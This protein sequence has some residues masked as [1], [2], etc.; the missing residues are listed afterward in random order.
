MKKKDGSFR[1]CIDCRELNKLTIKNRYPLLRIDDLFD[2]LQGSRYFLK[3]DLRSGYHQLRVREEDIPKTTFRTSEGIH[4]DPIKIE[5]VKNWKHPKTPT[6]FRSL[7]RLVGNFWRFIANFLKIAK[8]LTLLTQKDKKFEWGDEQENVFQTLKDML[9]DAPILRNKVI[10]YASRQLKIHE[11]NYTTYDLEL[12]TVRRWIELFSDYDCEIRCHPG[13][14]NVVAYPLSRKEWMKLRQARAMSMTIHSSI[15]AKILEA[16]SEASK[17]VNTLAEMLRGLDK[18]FERKE[19]GGLYFVERVWV[20]AYGNL[21]TLIMNEAHATKIKKDIALYVSKCLTCYKVKAEHQKPSGLLQQPEIPEWKWENITMDFIMKLPRTSSR[22]DSIWVIV[23]RLTKSAHFL[24]IRE[25]YRTEKLARLYINEIKALGTQLDLSTAYH[26][27][28]DGQI[29]IALP[30]PSLPLLLQS[31]YIPPLVD[32]RDD[33]LESEQPPRKSTVDAEERRQGI[34]NVGY[35]I[36]DT[37]VDPAEAV[38]E[39]AHMT[40]G[41]E[42]VWMAE[43]EAYASRE[44]WAHSIGL[45]QATHQEL[46]TYLDHVYAYETHLQ[47][48]QTHLHLQSTLIQ[49]Q[50]QVHETCFQMQQDELAA[51]RE[52]E[53][54]RQN[55][56]VETLRVIRDMRREMSDMQAELLS[57]REQQRRARQPGP[58]ARIPDHQDVSGDTD[59]HI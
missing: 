5:V 15:K 10:A 7:L 52:T 9:C 59:S 38:P 48:H 46:Q 13:K 50:H 27:Q 45:S 37:W 2:Q 58:E 16:Q 22:R 56:M 26:P 3:I 29:T 20:P 53:R 25:D 6:D 55:Q 30:S 4:V 12:G 54:R 44:A 43:E 35:G 51:L 34:R 17:D 23:D 18:Q 33:I 42:T 31:L 21:R 11:K 36:R 1:M 19:Y 57:L 40:V 32:C 8:P 24:A 41:E 39:I 47:A 49:T 28:T 14:A